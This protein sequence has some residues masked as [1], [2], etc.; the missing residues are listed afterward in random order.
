MACKPI[1]FV[2]GNA[3]KLEE[4]V[5]ILGKNFPYKVLTK[6]KISPLV[7]SITILCFVGCESKS[8]PPGATRRG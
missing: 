5:A 6:K 4:V 3:K 1:V 8:R 2:T 7:I